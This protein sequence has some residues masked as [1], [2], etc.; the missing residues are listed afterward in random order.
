MPHNFT[1][2]TLLIPTLALALACVIGVIIW[3]THNAHVARDREAV[4]RLEEDV[5]G[6]AATLSYFF[7][8][9]SN[10]LRNVADNRQ[11][12]T[13][14]ENKALGMS[15]EYGLLASRLAI[16]E[17]LEK[18]IADRSLAGERI[19]ADMALVDATGSVIAETIDQ[20]AAEHSAS[21]WSMALFASKRRNPHF[22]V[23]FLSSPPVI[24]LRQ[25]LAIQE[26][27]AGYVLTRLPLERLLKLLLNPVE[28]GSTLNCVTMGQ[29]M[30]ATLSGKADA[31][32]L[33]QVGE[34]PTNFGLSSRQMK[35]DPEKENTHE[36]FVL[37]A[38]I[39]GTPLQ[40]LTVIDSLE[41]LGSI[42]PWMVT[43]IS[44]L[45]SALT[46]GTLAKTWRSN[47]K[48]I[49][50]T[51]R[52][53][54]KTKAAETMRQKAQELQL[55][56]DSLPGY[57]FFKDAQG[58]Y[59]TANTNFCTLVGLWR[60]ELPGHTD[61]DLFPAQ[62]ADK[63]VANDL[64]ILSGRERSI[65]TEEEVEEDGS[66]HSFLSRKV[67][68]RNSEG[69][70]MGLIGVSFDIT[71]KK[72]V[73][74]ELEAA[75][76]EMEDRVASRTE[77]LANANTQLENE[78]LERKQALRDVNLVL[79]AISSLLI[80]VDNHGRVRKW[81]TA[82][83][84]IF[85]GITDTCIGKEFN[86]LDLRWDWTE[87]TR[88]VEKCRQN[89]HPVLINNLK[90]DR[91]DGKDGYLLLTISPLLDEREA[92]EGVLIL[93]SDTTDFK[94]L[95][96][97]LAQ[98]QKLQSIGQ[99]AAGIAHEINTPTQYVGDTITFLQEVNSQLMSVLDMI[100]NLTKSHPC[101]PENR[102]AIIN[103]LEQADYEF[104]REE[105]PTS[106]IRAKEGIER[107]ST[108]VRAMRSFSHIGESEKKAVNLNDALENTIT[109]SRNEWKYVAELTTE[110]HPN[111]PSVFCMPGEMNQALLN[112]VINA[113]HAVEGHTSTDGKQGHIHITSNFDNGFVHIAISDNGCGIPE[114]IRDR[115]FDPFFT[116]KEVGK[117]TGQG[118]TLVY[119]V[120]VN[121][122][123][124]SIGFDSEEG[125][126]TTFHIRLPISD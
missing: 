102:A 114:G 125:K 10:D 36:H 5:R 95:E 91:D 126:G 66:V 7:Y 32:T 39:D 100:V 42:Q 47:S 8:E 24:L 22:A 83:S 67:A 4:L 111:L 29:T 89:M 123:G 70:T 38:T 21:R 85:P 60:D 109:V 119:D 78:I 64:R 97:Q 68:I 30:I 57:A 118:L 69:T 92:L 96:V 101:P 9:R 12:L 94:L 2:S 93:G 19:Y 82:A 105:L 112:L 98:A 107:V 49:A 74:R 23:D 79:S 51:A 46:L 108:I 75:Y 58:R 34:P 50:L 117:G 3:N 99:L 80:G 1:R 37:W 45:L 59:V 90:Y 20:N 54:E 84:R 76:A 120:V 86:S 14:F 15:E 17:Y 61:H 121:K 27:I 87:V 31:L 77:E 25:P 116:T 52:L 71:E 53:E 55:L 40:V 41:Y 110:L 81:N 56:I 106:F 72:R 35:T 62:F 113:A 43:S 65:E 26:Q 48:Q 63:F 115:I 44:I 73:Q 28:A 11:V 88:G 13:Y 6:M 124:G 103:A 33:A 18:F 16:T 122:H 104:L